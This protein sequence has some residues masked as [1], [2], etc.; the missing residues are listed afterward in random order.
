MSQPPPSST[1]FAANITPTYWSASQ[2]LADHEHRTG[3]SDTKHSNHDHPHY[4]LTDPEYGHHVH[5][6]DHLYDQYYPAHHDYRNTN[7]YHNL[8]VN[9]EFGD[10]GSDLVDEVLEVNT[11]NCKSDLNISSETSST[12]PMI[13][14]HDRVAVLDIRGTDSPV[15]DTRVGDSQVTGI[16]GGDSQV[17]DIRGG[18]CGA[19]AREIQR[20]VTQV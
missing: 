1:S 12:L 17:T 5:P 9:D 4:C 7:H 18:D 20:N 2:L 3:A 16:G 10:Y 19:K 6:S 14:I 15:P 13:G 11:S 8:V